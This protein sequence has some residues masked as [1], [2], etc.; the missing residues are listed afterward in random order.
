MVSDVMMTNI[1]AECDTALIVV[2]REKTK[3]KAEQARVI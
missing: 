1:S 2:M 3:L